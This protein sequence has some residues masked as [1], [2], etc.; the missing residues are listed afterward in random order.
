MAVVVSRG[1]VDVD[2]FGGAL[3]L[4]AVVAVAVAVAEAVAVAVA[5]R[6]VVVVL[7]VVLVGRAPLRHLRA[8]LRKN[9][10]CGPGTLSNIFKQ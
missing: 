7:V 5:V 6:A 9:T 2:G 1:P 8:L 3:G 10:N 4:T